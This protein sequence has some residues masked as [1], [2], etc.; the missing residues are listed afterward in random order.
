MVQYVDI[1]PT[2][3]DLCGINKPKELD[4]NSFVEV[5]QGKPM[6]TINTSSGYILL[7]ALSL[8]QKAIQ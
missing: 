5:V 7:E 1:L 2:L 3:L 6:I 4:G 8:G